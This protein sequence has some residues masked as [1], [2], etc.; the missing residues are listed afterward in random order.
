M[1]AMF[2]DTKSVSSAGLVPR[3]MDPIAAE[4]QWRDQALGLTS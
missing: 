2:N 1:K 4:R 3:K